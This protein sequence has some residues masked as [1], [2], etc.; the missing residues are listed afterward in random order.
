MKIH[1]APEPEDVIW[2]NMEFSFC[3][4][5]KRII[6][7]YSLTIFL[8]CF[9]FQIVFS[10]N[11]VQGSIKVE[12]WAVI[13]KYTASFSISIVIS[14]LNAFLQFILR[15]FTQMEKQKSKSNY[16]LSYSIKLTFFT[17]TTS[18][19]VPFLSNYLNLLYKGLE[20]NN[21]TLI[22]N[23]LMLF[24][25]NSFFTPLIWTLNINLIIKK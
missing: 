13:I 6:I 8:I 9:A 23:M 22:N 11:K 1:L 25:V 17:L 19:V 12:N 20:Y 5:F 10:L 24:L 16:Y 14:I 18:A 4:R 21:K 3:Q 2:E 15:I 7:I